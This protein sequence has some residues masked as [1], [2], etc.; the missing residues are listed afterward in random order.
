MK[1]LPLRRA[2]RRAAL[3]SV[4]LATIF[5]IAVPAYAAHDNNGK[6]AH[7]NGHAAATTTR[8]RSASTTSTGTPANSNAIKPTVCGSWGPNGH[9]PSP[10]SS[11][12][13]F[14]PSDPDGSSNGG[15]DK[16]SGSGG[17]NSDQDGNNGCGNDTDREDDNNGWCGLKPTPSPTGTPTVLPTIIRKKTPG[18]PPTVLG[19]TIKGSS[20]TVLGLTLSRTGA[21][22]ALVA[23]AGLLVLMTGMVLRRA[24]RS[25]QRD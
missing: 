11:P 12:Q 16:P 2:L 20:P 5:A 24:S 15:A 8:G 1:G 7:G 13:G 6:R 21:Q 25:E 4:A 17:C 22:I 9:Q 23:F 19:E 14:S 18:T 3:C 10:N